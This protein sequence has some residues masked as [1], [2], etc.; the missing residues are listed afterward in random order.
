MSSNE[1]NN[2]LENNENRPPSKLTGGIFL[3]AVAGVSILGGFGMTLAMAKRKDPNMFTRGLVPSREIPD[4]GA[5][6][7]LRAL[8]WGT[9]WSVSGVGI[10]SLTVWKVLGV[11]SMKEFTDKMQS[12]MPKIPKKESQG[13]S[14]FKTIRELFEY[15]SEEDRSVKD[16]KKS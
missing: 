10:L 16:S 1:T 2:S 7:A 8:G 13:R 5:S 14:E 11:H 6:L 12:L 9:L 15:L 4:S 3:T